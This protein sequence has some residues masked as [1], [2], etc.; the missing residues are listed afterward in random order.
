[1]NDNSQPKQIDYLGAYLET[2][3]ERDVFSAVSSAI[4]SNMPEHHREQA[5]R[6]LA[7][8][9]DVRYPPLIIDINTG[10]YKPAFS[11]RILD[12]RK[13]KEHKL[14][15]EEA[16]NIDDVQTCREVDALAINYLFKKSQEG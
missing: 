12:L 1:M 5:L 13:G 2:T 10:Q 9:T 11:P 8:L 4:Q 15:L 6:Y 7:K 3:I 14:K 16:G